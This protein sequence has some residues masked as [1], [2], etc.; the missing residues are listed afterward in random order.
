MKKK[1]LVVADVPDW[2]FDKIYKALDKSCEEWEVDVAYITTKSIDK[3][4]KHKN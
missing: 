2:A 1:V 3:L 4:S